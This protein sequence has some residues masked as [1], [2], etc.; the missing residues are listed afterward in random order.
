MRTLTSEL[1]LEGPLAPLDEKL[2]V[3]PVKNPTGPAGEPENEL[4]KPD[5][6]TRIPTL[7][8]HLGALGG[9]FFTPITWEGIALLV[10]MYY[11]RMWALSSFN[12]RY[13][14]HRA[15]KTSRAFQFV[16]GVL[17]TM[18]TQNGILWW[19]GN[20]RHHHRFS[21]QAEDIHSPKQKGFWWSHMGWVL[22][23]RV[24]ETK[25][26]LVRDLEKFPELRWLDRYWFVV[27]LVFAGALYAIGGWFAFYWG[28]LLNTV[29][30]F[31]GTFTVNSI[32]HIWG[33][34]RYETTDTSRNNFWIAL[35]TCGEGW[36][37]N[38]HHYQSSARQGFFW[39]EIDFSYYVLK[40][41]E[42]LG[43]IW[44]LRA[45]PKHVLEGAGAR[46]AAAFR[47]QTHSK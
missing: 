41:L 45:P 22:S 5:W 33:S 39:W 47:L 6:K 12:H 28:F 44:D 37:N 32:A 42:K 19:A 8:L 23:K 3:V 2:N 25:F 4:D 18:T 43:L 10:G 31:Q 1:P 15:F 38:H 11:F 35:I 27:T 46:S 16:L 36:H 17:G 20:H 40:V 7:I 34:R 21:D 30:L 24:N 29:V 14:S 9:L 26:D 13:F